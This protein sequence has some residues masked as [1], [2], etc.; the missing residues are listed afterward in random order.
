V[1]DRRHGDSGCEASR[2]MSVLVEVQPPVR[3]FVSVHEHKEA[4]HLGNSL[5]L[6]DPALLNSAHKICPPNKLGAHMVAPFCNGLTHV[7][8][9][10]PDPD[11]DLDPAPT[12]A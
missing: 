10:Y 7:V 3:G 1:P 12:Q 5:C 6:A 9:T 11:P 4:V 8:R 2:R